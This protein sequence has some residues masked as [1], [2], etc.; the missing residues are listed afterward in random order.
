VVART[1]RF[2]RTLVQATQG[3]NTASGPRAVLAADLR[4]PDGYALRL[5]GVSTL[6]GVAIRR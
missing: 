2:A 1:E 3:F 6:A 5:R 4:H